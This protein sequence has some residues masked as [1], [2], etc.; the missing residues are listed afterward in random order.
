MAF[1]QELIELCS[2]LI[3]NAENVKASD[4]DT[5]Y[6]NSEGFSVPIRSTYQNKYQFCEADVLPSACGTNAGTITL[7]R[8]LLVEILQ[9][10]DKY[11][12]CVLDYDLY[13]RVMKYYHTSSL[14]RPFM[15][16]QERLI[17]IMGPWHI[18][19]VLTEAVWKAFSALIFAP[20]WL[21]AKAAKVPAIPSVVEITTIFV[22]VAMTSKNQPR[23]STNQN[24]PI[25]VSIQLLMYHFIPLVS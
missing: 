13:W 7:M 6:D 17:L 1:S 23:W 14:W 18:Y 10:S 8:Y 11:S 5:Y 20:M 16:Y 21:H 25:C 22:A 2:T 15:F 19:K 12:I 3:L 24:D 9:P 4:F